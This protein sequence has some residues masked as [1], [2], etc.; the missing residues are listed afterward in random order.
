MLRI[1]VSDASGET[2]ELPQGESI[3][4]RG[5]G[6]TVRFNDDAVSRQHARLEVEDGNVVVEDM[7]SSNGTYVNGEPLRMPRRLRDHDEIQIGKRILT[8]LV[9][10]DANRERLSKTM[11]RVPR[12]TYKFCR[13]CNGALPAGSL[14]CPSCGTHRRA[15]GSGGPGVKRRHPRFPIDVPV[16]YMSASLNAEAEARDVSLSGMLIE[17]EEVDRVGAACTLTIPDLDEGPFAVT[18]VVR[19]V[20]APQ[21]AGEFAVP[22]G[23]G[24][25]FIHLDPEIEDRLIRLVDRARADQQWYAIA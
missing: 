10:D 24:I 13:S 7:G 22:G 2:V 25:E 6:C 16:S 12:V 17:C 1:F 14:V 11:D 3:I 5:L 15:T 23:M 8:L 21:G 9:V 20:F 4:G 19:R 18:G